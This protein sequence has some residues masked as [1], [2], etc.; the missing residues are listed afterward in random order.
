M[1]ELLRKWEAFVEGGAANPPTLPTKLRGDELTQFL[2]HLSETGEMKTYTPEDWMK[3]ADQ[4]EMTGDEVAQFLEEVAA[5]LPVADV[6]PEHETP[7]G[8]PVQNPG[9]EEEEEEGDPVPPELTEVEEAEDADC[10]ECGETCD[11][12][13]ICTECGC[14]PDC[15]EC[16]VEEE[17]E[18]QED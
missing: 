16:E 15:C 5:W 10:E 12:Q 13:D 2:R 1:S 17:E 3:V 18:E 4:Y 8:W 7:A 9:E 14:C 6:S 11:A